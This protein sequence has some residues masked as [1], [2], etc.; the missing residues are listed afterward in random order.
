MGEAQAGRTDGTM[1]EGEAEPLILELEERM[2][3]RGREVL[4]DEK[5]RSD[6]EQ[7]KEEEGWLRGRS[8]RDLRPSW[9]TGRARLCSSSLLQTTASDSHVL[10]SLL[11][12]LD[13]LPLRPSSPDDLPS[14]LLPART[15]S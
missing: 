12:H 11:P 15:Q 2:L 13:L 1:E 5:A 14:L 7:R 6:R 4:V 9:T 3:I 8:S 10:H